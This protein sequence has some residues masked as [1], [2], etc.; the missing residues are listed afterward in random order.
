[1]KLYAISDLHLSDAVNR[2]ALEGVAE[3][4]DDWIVLAGDTGEKEA[5]LDWAL[6]ILTHRFRQVVWVPGNHDLW[7]L[8]SDREG[9]RGEAKYRR[10]VTICL[11]QDLVQLPRIPRFSIWCGTRQTER[12][13]VRFSASVLVYGHLHVRGTRF[14]DGV[15]F[16]EVSLGLSP[17]NWSQEDGIRPYLREILPGKAV[18]RPDRNE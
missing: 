2:R 8:P 15:R 10:L 11:R 13:H 18:D 6:S 16:E 9:L 4:P 17:W 12:W 3:H 7:T 5:H 14:R 1:M